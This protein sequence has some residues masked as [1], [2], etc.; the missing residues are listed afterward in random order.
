MNWAAWIGT[1]ASI[2]GAFAV[3]LGFAGLGYVA[4]TLGSL[5]WFALGLLRGDKALALLNA[6]FFCAN[7]VGLYRSF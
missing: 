3:A 5:L 4:F 1:S 2:I 7:I 6:V